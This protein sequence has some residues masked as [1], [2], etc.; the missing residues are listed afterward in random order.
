M[1]RKYYLTEIVMLAV[2]AWIMTV[3]IKINNVMGEV[4]V[5][6]VHIDSLGFDLKSVNL[7]VGSMQEEKDDFNNLDFS[8]AFKVMYDKHGQHHLFEWR[9]RVYTTDLN[10]PRNITIIEKEEEASDGRQ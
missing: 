5:I 8:E 10:Q 2:L 3:N 1:V 4:D 9:G 7:V 6:K